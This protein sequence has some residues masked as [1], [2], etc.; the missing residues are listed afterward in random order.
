[1][2]LLE[3]FAL[4]DL[5]LPN[6]VVMAPMAR[7][8]ADPAT[9]VPGT[10]LLEYY[11]QRA[12]AGLIITEAIAVSQ[13]GENIYRCA[14]LYNA[15][16]VRGWKAIT[17]AV[18]AAGGHIFAQLLHAGRAS[19]KLNQRDGEAPVAPSVTRCTTRTFTRNGFE[20]MSLP[21]ELGIDE[22]PAIV[23]DF[24]KASKAASEAGFDGVEIHAA[25]GYLLDQ[26]I[27]SS[28]NLR[29]DAY[30]GSITNRLRLML[31]VVEAVTAAN[32]RV[33]IRF[34]PGPAQDAW[35]DDPQA[36]FSEAID[37]MNAYSLSYVHVVE[38]VASGNRSSKG[39]DYKA[40]R[41]RYRGVWIANNGFDAENGEAALRERCADLIS[42]GRPFI[43]NPDLVARIAQGLPFAP[44]DKRTY[45]AGE[46]RGL[47][48]YPAV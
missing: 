20:S 25:N 46:A 15:E 33:G 38:G 18:H 7:A 31:E 22:L 40:L 23:E 17:D 43:S 16:Q 4:G 26:F 28:T 32:P 11:Q 27:K 3:G 6:R 13:R 34:A 24:G 10:L 29:D 36:V 9:G 48:D 2:L 35:D 21:R 41:D 1:M 30:G 8:R 42:F 45:F 12:S 19:S 37:A 5:R 39:I 14:G 44:S 47:I